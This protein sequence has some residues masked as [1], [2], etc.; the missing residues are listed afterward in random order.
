MQV[1]R[2]T[3]IDHPLIEYTLQ[4]GILLIHSRILLIRA[5]TALDTLN[6]M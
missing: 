4:A 2:Q 1:L 5:D 6:V 3:G